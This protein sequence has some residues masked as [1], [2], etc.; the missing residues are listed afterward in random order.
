MLPNE[1]RPAAGGY[2]ATKSLDGLTPSISPI[3]GNWDSFAAHVDHALAVVVKTSNDRAKRRLFLTLASAERHRDK[4]LE[5]GHD[6]EVILVA[7]QPVQVDAA[8]QVTP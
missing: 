6:A 1:R 2:E 4:A 3:V 5:A 8:K 7:L